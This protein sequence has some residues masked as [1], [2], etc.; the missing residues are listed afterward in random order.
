[1]IGVKDRRSTPEVEKCIDSLEVLMP[2][3]ALVV[4]VVVLTIFIAFAG[5][6]AWGDRQTRP[7]RPKSPPHG[8]PDRK[9]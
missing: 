4:S 5:V 1:L 8:S 3:D 9:G 7:E 2:I 6:V